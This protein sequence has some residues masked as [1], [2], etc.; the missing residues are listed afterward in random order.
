MGTWVSSQTTPY[1]FRSVTST[2]VQTLIF[3]TLNYSC[4]QMDS[5]CLQFLP[6]MLQITTQIIVLKHRVLS[7]FVSPEVFNKLSLPEA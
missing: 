5:M 6:F 3:V 1:P 2:I 7:F 4:D